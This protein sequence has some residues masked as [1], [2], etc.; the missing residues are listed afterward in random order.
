[1]GAWLGVLASG[2]RIDL[3][4]SLRG[5]FNVVPAALFFGGLAVLAFGVLPRAT[6][7]VAYGSVA[8]GYVVQIVAGLA[9]APAWLQDLSPFWHIAPVPA[10]SPNVG[11]SIAFLALAVALT[12][13]GSLAFA[14][15]DVASD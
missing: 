5:T 1:M 14:H 3:Y 11:A 6:S 10:R 12:V 8:L 2:A 13:A 7:F 9:S 15:R 4:D